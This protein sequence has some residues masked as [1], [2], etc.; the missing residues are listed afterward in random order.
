VEEKL[1]RIIF[2]KLYEDLSH[3][4]I[5]EHDN[6]VWFIDADKKYWYLEYR[7]DGI[8]YWRHSF[9]NKFFELFCMKIEEFEP[10]IGEWCEEVL[11][12]KVVNSGD[13]FFEQYE[14]VKE[15]LDSKVNKLFSVGSWCINQ[16]NEVKE[17]LDSKVVPLARLHQ[18]S[19]V[20]ECKVFT[21]T[22]FENGGVNVIEN[23]L[24][25]KVN[26]MLPGDYMT[27]GEADQVLESKVIKTIGGDYNGNYRIEKVLNREKSV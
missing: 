4:Q 21:P 2:R 16:N 14:E 8:L 10:F 12:C 11:N 19:E 9:F 20:I 22:M 23:V 24:N 26:K 6:S 3:V 13:L 25:H 27:D 17:V 15:V 5:I 18:V 1:K 7:N